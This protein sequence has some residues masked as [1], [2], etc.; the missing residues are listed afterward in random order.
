MK[1]AVV[2]NRGTGNV[3][4][5]FGMPAGRRLA[6]ELTRAASGL[7]IAL[8][9]GT[10]AWPSVAGLA[11]ADKACVCAVGPIARDR[12]IHE[13]QR[14]AVSH[15]GMVATAHYCATAAGVEMLVAGGN[16]FDAAVAAAFALGGA[17][18]VTDVPM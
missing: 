3:I 12:R 1:I 4:N 13:P 10:S 14:L 15:D 16:A 8:E 5:L 17:G 11:P 18:E 6:A 7:D 2:Y 9:R